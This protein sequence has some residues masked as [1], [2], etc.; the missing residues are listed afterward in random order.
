MPRVKK[1]LEEFFKLG[2]LE[3]G[4]HLNGDEAMALGAAFRAANL[5][6]AFRVRKVGISDLSSFGVSVSLEALPK[7]EG[8]LFHSMLNILKGGDKE[9]GATDGWHRQASLY[10]RKS[11]VPSKAKT[12]AFQYDK[13]ILCRLEYDDEIPLPA[14]TDKLIAVYNVTGISDF[15]KETAAKGLGS[16]KVHLS[17]LLD[18]S[19]MV[20]L[21][22]AEATV[23]LP[24]EKDDESS[25]GADGKDEEDEREEEGKNS[26]SNAASESPAESGQNATAEAAQDASNST[27]TDIPSDSGKNETAAEADKAKKDK[28]TKKEKKAKK[29]T[30]LRRVLVIEENNQVLQ[31]GGWE[32][33]MLLG[34]RARLRALA[35]ADELR[36]AKEAAMNELEAYVY[37]VK[38]RISDE[39]KELSKVSTETQR[40]S[41]LDLCAAA[42]DWLDTEGQGQELGIY[43]NKLSAI[44]REAEPIFLRYTELSERPAAVAKARKAL[45]DVRAEVA[46]WEV[47][48]PQVTDEEKKSLLD[49]VDKAEKW[50]NDK[51]ELQLTKASSEEPAFYSEDVP[52]QLKALAGIRERL[53]RKPKP[54]PEKVG[55]FYFI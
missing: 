32:P 48:L 26:T 34:A 7:E 30:T 31:P 36:K 3:L 38:N 10:P 53:L 50:I 28:K 14:G 16:P 18:N 43:K 49:A 11:L 51:E 12:V 40:Q 1:V 27:T 52:L 55:S 47:K 5:S 33:A 37:R 13:D 41:V 8:G 42:I 24:A 19:G 6:T 35:A 46:K 44:R 17:F 22:R 54:A 15:A 25:K 20:T 29:D 21:S 39:E 4:Q 9:K 23:E 2:N 45:S